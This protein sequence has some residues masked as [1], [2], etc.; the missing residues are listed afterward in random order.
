MQCR[1]VSKS[2]VP[3][4]FCSCAFESWSFKESIHTRD[5]WCCLRS[6]LHACLDVIC[7][8]SIVNKLI[9]AMALFLSPH[10]YEQ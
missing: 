9:T 6:W 4:S 10:K 3:N 1:Y 8:H 2:R 5:N 7:G